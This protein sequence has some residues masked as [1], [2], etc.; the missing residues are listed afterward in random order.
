MA[1]RRLGDVEERDELANAHLAGVLAQNIEELQP[2]W[3]AERLGDLGEPERLLAP[4][5]LIYLHLSM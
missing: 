5:M 1:E 3:I 2:D 4:S